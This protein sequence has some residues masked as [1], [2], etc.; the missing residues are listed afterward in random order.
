MG[1]ALHLQIVSHV[2]LHILPCLTCLS[3][4]EESVPRLFS[5]T[6]TSNLVWHVQTCKALVG[7]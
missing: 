7:S 3:N 5:D 6:S 4:N 1:D 2:V